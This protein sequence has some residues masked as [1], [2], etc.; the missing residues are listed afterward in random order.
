MMVL[1]LT[2]KVFS[3]PFHLWYVPLLTMYPYRNLKE[4]LT[5]FGLALWMLMLDTSSLFRVPELIVFGR[6][7]LERLRG[8]SR[9]LPMFLIGWFSVKNAR[10]ITS[11]HL[12]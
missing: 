5:M 7:P 3:S 8:A 2:T 10:L 11:R 9:F 12:D 4:Q 1:F 6:T